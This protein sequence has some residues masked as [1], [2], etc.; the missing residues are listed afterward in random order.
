[1]QISALA[2]SCTF[3]IV[4]PPVGAAMFAYAALRQGKDMDLLPKNLNGPLGQT[5]LANG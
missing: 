4:T 3:V 1:M 2:L 5:N